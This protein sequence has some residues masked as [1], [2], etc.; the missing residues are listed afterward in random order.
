MFLTKTE[1]RTLLVNMVLLL[2]SVF[3][4]AVTL[5]ITNIITGVFTISLIVIGLIHHIAFAN[6]IYIRMKQAKTDLTIVLKKF[7]EGSE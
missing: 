5:I 3:S 7:E 4:I 1:S 6:P 2:L